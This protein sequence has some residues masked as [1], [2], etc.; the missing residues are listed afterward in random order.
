MRV[1]MSLGCTPTAAAL[2]VCYLST[3]RHALHSQTP[4]FIA[5]PGTRS[6]GS[7][8]HPQPAD[9]TVYLPAVLSK[10][11]PRGAVTVPVLVLGE[12][13]L[14]GRVAELVCRDLN[15]Y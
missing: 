6:Q 11:S 2:R 7:E 5:R 10:G 1:T 15:P 8:R 13:A 12:V 14:P 3:R 9:T 4:L